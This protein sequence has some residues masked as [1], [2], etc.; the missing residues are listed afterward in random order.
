MQATRSLIL[1]LS[2]AALAMQAQAADIRPWMDPKLDPD[3]RARLVDREMTLDERLGLLHGVMAFPF[4]GPLPPE[5]RGS[6]GYI[7]GIPRLG[8]PALQESDASLGLTN[9]LEIRKGEGGT[10]MPSGLALASTFNRDLAFQ[11]GRMIGHE[12]WS[13]GFNVLLGGGVNL[14]REPRGGRNFEYLGE[15]PLLAGTLAGE[16]V[17]GTQSEHVISTVKHFVLNSQETLRHAVSANIPLAALRESDL[18]AFELA[19]ERGRPGAVMC[20]YNRINGDFACDNDRLLNGVL[21]G[22]WGYPGWVMSDWGAVPGLQAAVHGLDQQSGQQL[23]HAVYFGAPLKAAVEAGAIPPE[24][25][26]EMARRILRSMFAVGVF[27]NPPQRGPVDADADAA[28]AQHAA[29]EGIVLFK[30]QDGLLPLATT[31]RRVV[32]IGGFADSGVLSGGGSSQVIPPGGSVMRV[33]VAG[34]GELPGGF[35][36]MVFLPSSPL[37]ALRSAAPGDQVSFVAGEYPSAAVAAARQADVAIVFATQWTTEGADVPDLTLP[38]GQDQLIAAVAA[39]NPNTIVV[40]ETGGP[41]LMPW[42]G[43]VKAVIEAWYPGV[44]GGEALARVLTGAVDPSGRLPITFPTGESQLPHPVLPGV[45]QIAKDPPDIG[46]DVTEGADAGYR[47]Y[48]RQGLQPLFPFGYG[49][50]YTSFS[51][52]GLALKAGDGLELSFDVTNIGAKPGREA[53][54]AYLVSAAGKPVM[55]LIG[56]D[57][58]ELAPG[59]TRRV[60]M[61]ADP[62]LLGGY[63]DARHGWWIEPGVY[64]VS[65]GASSQASSLQG[66]ARLKG[67]MVRRNGVARQAQRSTRG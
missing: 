10:P 37:K 3:E 35:R 25:V 58:I 31:G 34:E 55:R 63:D 8:V 14:T 27:E 29:E 59:E 44:R 56:F 50:S 49:L 18:L 53:P 64:R 21:K 61:T 15:D 13:A 5:A 51:F 48:A 52:G 17:R 12:A 4:L 2:L 30:N 9:P 23:D 54:Q 19:I 65:V 32:L 1:G 43:Q 39:A 62:R 47:W 20:S 28:V 41:V 67:G 24:R 57:K 33:P 11:G 42:L 46:Y 7:P 66:E 16:A 40:L 26:S 36:S 38:N 6:A 60:T 22:D 45:G